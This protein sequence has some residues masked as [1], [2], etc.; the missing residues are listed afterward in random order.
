MEN[1][2]E[3]CYSHSKLKAEIR[4]LYAF[5]AVNDSASNTLYFN[6]GIKS[7][8]LAQFLTNI[9]KNSALFNQNSI[10]G[11]VFNYNEGHPYKG[12]SIQNGVLLNKVIASHLGKE[13]SL[14]EPPSTFSINR[15]RYTVHPFAIKAVIL[16]SKELNDMRLSD[17]YSTSRLLSYKYLNLAVWIPYFS[18]EL[19]SMN[20]SNILDIGTLKSKNHILE[21]NVIKA[22]TLAAS[23]PLII[24]EKP[25]M[26]SNQMNTVFDREI[27]PYLKTRVEPLNQECHR[28]WTTA[29][30]DRV[31]L[32]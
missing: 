21:P 10:G 22:S 20:E 24:D 9:N 29:L 31:S 18:F 19:N 6:T 2:F 27:I 17:S 30:D 7:D 25:I 12:F 1:I 16:S 23:E 8:G 32:E 13:V 26:D 14:I 3:F 5:L 28:Q 15:P 4:F 11:L